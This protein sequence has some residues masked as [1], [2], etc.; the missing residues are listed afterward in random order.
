MQRAS[1]RLRPVRSRTK[2]NPSFETLS[3]CIDL[4]TAAR[5][6]IVT[7][8]AVLDGDPVE[9]LWEASVVAVDVE[10]YRLSRYSMELLCVALPDGT[11]FLFDAPSNALKQFLEEAPATL[12]FWDCRRD[13]DALLHAWGIRVREESVVD[14]QVLDCLFQ[15]MQHGR[16]TPYRRALGHAE[17]DYGIVEHKADL[18]ASL[19]PAWPHWSYVWSL[20]PLPSQAVAY[21]AADVRALLA[22][23]Q[24]IVESGVLRPQ[25]VRQVR[26]RSLSDAMVFRDSL[27]EITLVTREMN[28]LPSWK[29]W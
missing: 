21:A 18:Q 9:K 11:T 14:C 2:K 29:S 28:S 10:G 6:V 5:E 3:T 17:Q 16:P 15:R 1:K 24:H 4:N 22:V 12:L 19:D 23:F 26:A 13:T 8:D 27:E 7:G 20:R 25:H